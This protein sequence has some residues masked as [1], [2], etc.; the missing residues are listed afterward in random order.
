LERQQL[1]KTAPAVMVDSL[2]LAASQHLVAVAALGLT[3]MSEDRGAQVA[4]GVAMPHLLMVE[5]QQPGRGLLEALVQPLLRA[6]TALAE[7]VVLVQ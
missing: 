5:P 1:A 2:H 7:V 6:Q 3:D 4:A